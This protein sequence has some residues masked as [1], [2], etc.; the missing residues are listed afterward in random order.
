MIR[1]SA[2]SYN[3]SMIKAV[4][5]VSIPVKDQ[6]R[7]LEFYTEKLGFQI[8]TDQPF[9]GEQRWIELRIPGSD[10]RVVVFTPKG[11]ADRVGTFSNVTFLS[12][13]V[14]RT[15]REMSGKGVEFVRGPERAAWGTTA[16]FKDQDGNVF[17]LSSK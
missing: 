1:T 13:D 10:T 8:L 2:H 12:D 5:F 6:D 9:D 7:A 11:Q 14:E 17:C 3:L 16:I 4:K 15:H